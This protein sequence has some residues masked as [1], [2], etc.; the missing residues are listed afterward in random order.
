MKNASN[1]WTLVPV[2][3]VFGATQVRAEVQTF[4]FTGTVAFVRDS[5]STERSDLLGS[6]VT[7]S[8]SYDPALQP[9]SVSYGS[10]MYPV[11][12]DNTYDVPAPSNI[13]IA[14]GNH[15]YRS[16]G[17]DVSVHKYSVDLWATVLPQGHI[18]VDGMVDVQA[19][20]YSLSLPLPPGN[21]GANSEY[22]LP[23]NFDVQARKVQGS[24][25]KVA[26]DPMGNML[27]DWRV[28]FTVDS[29]S[30]VPEPS[31]WLTFLTGISMMALAIARGRCTRG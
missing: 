9:K 31:T 7:G 24:L 8:F 15:Q 4:R 29:V 21:P 14:V 1:F 6:P 27:R 3:L 10:S 30:A 16:D 17:I 5:G 23:V 18:Y 25:G 12:Q 28:D 22:G 13:E 26:Y 20:I 2:I 11:I 19:Q